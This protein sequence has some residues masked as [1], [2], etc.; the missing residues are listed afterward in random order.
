MELR[1][2]WDLIVR[3]RWTFSVTVAVVLLCAVAWVLVKRPVY[4]AQGKLL[5]VEDTG[6]SGIGLNTKAIENLAFQSVGRSD[7]IRTQIALL[8]T[9]PV[10][11]ETI[12]RCGLND[13]LGKPW[14]ATR[15]RGR[16]TFRTLPSTNII[17]IACRY[18][19]PVIA[20]R[21]VD[22]LSLVFAEQN[23]RLNRENAAAGKDFVQTQLVLLEEKFG[24]AEDE[25]ME[26]QR[27]K[28]IVSLSQEVQLDVGSL[29]MLESE[30]QQIQ[31]ELLGLKAEKR[32]LEESK[33]DQDSRNTSLYGYYSNTLLLID[34][35]IESLDAKGRSTRSMIAGRRKLLERLPAQEVEYASL[36]SSKTLAHNLYMKLL[37]VYEDFKIREASVVANIKIVEPALVSRV[38]VEPN[39]KR[40]AGQAMALGLVL[41]FCLVLGVNHFDDTPRAIEDVK[42]TLSLNML[43]TVPWVKN[44]HPLFVKTDPTSLAAEALRLLHTNL[45]FSDTWG[46]EHLAIMFTSSQPA[47]GKS[48]IATN[49]ALVLAAA[50]KKAAVVSMDL[51]RPTF[52]KILERK[53]ARGITDYLSGDAALADIE[54]LDSS[55]GITIIPEGKLPS[56][57][58][59]LIGSRK[60]ADFVDAVRH[61]FEVTIFDTPPIPVVSETLDIARHM[62]G[63]IVVVDMENSS[64]RTLRYVA[65]LVGGKNLPLL[66]MVIN[67]YGKRMGKYYGYYKRYYRTYGASEEPQRAAVT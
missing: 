14:P 41:G 4:E 22:T 60:M 32:K 19:D 64:V 46:K 40:I 37:E 48:T 38:P 34:S 9:R 43:A 13:A 50:G 61:D 59:E 35:R 24:K 57:P 15:L 12:L 17:S 31:T 6:L 55:L 45:K 28:G 2:Y 67:K 36:L 49:F 25:L 52:E 26:Y 63:V 58:A 11:S 30:Y 3:R 18:I 16:L 23:Q 20:A 1:E 10:L 42:R 5:L 56:N 44:I 62:D 47:E 65:E 8:E 54:Y 39:K 7:P 21:I 66:G 53:F 51:R 33:T 27:T 29:A